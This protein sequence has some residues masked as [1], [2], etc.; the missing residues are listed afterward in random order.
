MITAAEIAKALGGQVSGR[1]TALVPGPGHSRR[2]RSLAVRL[3]PNAPDGFLTFSHCGDAWQSCRDHVRRALG[4][5]DWRP[6]DGQQRSI[7]PRRL[8]EWDLAAVDSEAEEIRPRD[9][10]DLSR[11]AKA[12][13]LWSEGKDPRGTLA[14]GYLRRH[15]GLNLPDELA[16]PVLRFHPECPWRDENTGTIVRVPALLAAF[17]CIDDDDVCAVHRVGLNQDGSKIDRRMLGLVR[18]GAIKF[19]EAADCLTIGEGIET[20]LAGRQLGFRPAWALGSVGAISFFPVIDGV[21]QL[22]I[23]A[24]VGKPS[25]DAVAICGRRW[26]RAGKQVRVIMPEIGSDMNDE[27]IAKENAY[28]ANF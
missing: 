21:R 28:A 24:E 2:D 20:T 7:P 22:T 15:R 12:Q 5:P 11:I 9:E 8:R 14:E 10:N 27:L 13:K 26:R 23:L 18:R 16:G 6:G 19:D 4:L 3:D 1:D 25:A 17:R